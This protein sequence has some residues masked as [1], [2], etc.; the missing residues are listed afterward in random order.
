L[1]IEAQLTLLEVFFCPHYR[2]LSTIAIRHFTLAL[3][4]LQEASVLL[5]ILHTLFIE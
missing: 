3:F 5:N 4:I 2:Y 1:E